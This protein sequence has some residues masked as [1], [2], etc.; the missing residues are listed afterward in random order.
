MEKPDKVELVLRLKIPVWRQ[1]IQSFRN[2]DD[3]ISK[4]EDTI[5][6]HLETYQ[7]P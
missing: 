5:F 1:E 2:L 6:E 3:L 7:K 4:I